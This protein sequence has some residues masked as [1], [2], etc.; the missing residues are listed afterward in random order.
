MPII[1]IMLIADAWTRFIFR[2]RDKSVLV[3]HLTFCKSRNTFNQQV[4][5]AG[6]CVYVG[7]NANTV[8]VFPFNTHRMNFILVK[9]K[10][11]QLGRLSSFHAYI[12]DGTA[13]FWVER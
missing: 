6:R 9:K 8:N 7:G 1:S 13:P 12:A 4:K 10:R 2:E 11:I 3:F 5:V